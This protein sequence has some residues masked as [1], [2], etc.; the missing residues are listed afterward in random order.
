MTYGNANA[1]NNE[2]IMNNVLM[3]SHWNEEAGETPVLN[4]VLPFTQTLR[5][6]REPLDSKLVKTREGWTD[7]SG[8]KHMVEYVEWHTVA[9]ILDRHAPTWGHTIKKITQMGETV[10]VI[11]AITIN[12]VTREGIGTGNANTETGIKKAEHDALKRAAIKF[13]IARDLYQR[14]GEHHEVING[15]PPK[16]QP[17]PIPANPLAKSVSELATPKQVV[18]I[19]SLCRDLDID[20]DVELQETMKLDCKVE[21][22]SRRAASSFIDHLKA[23][24]EG[25]EIPIV[26]RAS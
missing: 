14:D 4:N 23:L 21:E 24:Q 25:S 13:G 20:V 7:Y 5:S 8:N 16:P 2:A 18:L 9:D 1:N 6:L 19:R 26:R 15:I 10:V 22:L 11:A 17:K 12:G 3:G